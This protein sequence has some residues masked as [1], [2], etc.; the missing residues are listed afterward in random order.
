MLLVLVL[1][2]APHDERRLPAWRTRRSS[3]TARLVHARTLQHATRGTALTST[4]RDACPAHRSSQEAA[5][6]LVLRDGLLLRRSPAATEASASSALQLIGGSK[7]KLMC[8]SWLPDGRRGEACGSSAHPSPAAAPPSSPASSSACSSS[9]ATAA[10]HPCVCALALLCCLERAGPR[11]NA[12]Q[13]GTKAQQL[14]PCSEP[15][16]THEHHNNKHVPD[17][18]AATRP[19]PACSVHHGPEQVRHTRLTSFAA[20]QPAPTDTRR[21][22]RNQMKQKLKP[23]RV[24]QHSTA[25]HAAAA[26]P[27]HPTTSCRRRRG[28][29]T[30]KQTPRPHPTAPPCRSTN[31]RPGP[32]PLPPHAP[33][34]PPLGHH[35]R[36]HAAG[37]LPRLLL[38]LR[39]RPQRRRGCATGDGFSAAPTGCAGRPWSRPSW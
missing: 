39:R 24:A 34:N 17:A 18:A 11:H 1:M 15:T 19:A 38:L 21:F 10:C 33:S 36:T 6:A 26:S 13:S 14:E 28:D 8:R 35:P 2:L 31:D 37:Q 7:G 16:N 9:S 20:R 30:A 4:R 32:H 22:D 29:C 23:R 25:Q 3:T 12:P 5:H 27:C